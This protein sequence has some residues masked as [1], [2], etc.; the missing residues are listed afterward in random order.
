[1]AQVEQYTN[2][3]R[4]HHHPNTDENHPALSS[5]PS[6]PG[7]ELDPKHYEHHDQDLP[8]PPLFSPPVTNTTF[9]DTSFDR[10]EDLSIDSIQSH[11]SLADIND[12]SHEDHSASF[13]E[14]RTPESIAPSLD[15]VPFITSESD[16]LSVDRAS[17]PPEIISKAQAHDVDEVKEET[18]EEQHVDDHALPSTSEKPVSQPKSLDSPAE[19]V[20]PPKP[21]SSSMDKEEPKIEADQP[22]VTSEH[23][24]DPQEI[25]LPVLKEAP[26]SKIVGLVTNTAPMSVDEWLD[27]SRT[28]LQFAIGL[29][30]IPWSSL[31]ILTRSVNLFWTLIFTQPLVHPIAGILLSIIAPSVL[32][33]SLVALLISSAAHIDW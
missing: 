26:R 24:P 31:V 8:E 20:E 2:D 21:I 29:F 12:K 9:D 14:P 11:S 27:I 5:V 25:P 33:T 10:R 19:A 23:H 3:Q 17:Q 28:E 32:Y 6:L 15:Y 18:P 22:P 4:V 1:M 30:A 13:N 7:P 16:A